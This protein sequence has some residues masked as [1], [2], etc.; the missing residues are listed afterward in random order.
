MNTSLYLSEQRNNIYV[1]PHSSSQ[2]HDCGFIIAYYPLV[3]TKA[4]KDTKTPVPPIPKTETKAKKPLHQFHPIIPSPST[5]P[6]F[7]TTETTLPIIP[8]PPTP[9]SNLLSNANNPDPAAAA[10]ERRRECIIS[11]ALEAP[12]VRSPR[13]WMRTSQSG[14]VPWRM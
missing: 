14:M 2:I 9:S 13:L 4:P 8:S 7:P 5:T 3:V 11:P 10:A 1:W 6:P 12:A